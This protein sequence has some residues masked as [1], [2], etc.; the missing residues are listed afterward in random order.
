M[1][2]VWGEYAF[3]SSVTIRMAGG[4]VL[5]WL[6]A[7]DLMPA[8][9]IGLVAVAPLNAAPSAV[10]GLAS[11]TRNEL[12]HLSRSLDKLRLVAEGARVPLPTR[13]GSSGLIPQA[14]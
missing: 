2:Y 10:G 4:Q 12:K 1:E 7:P 11:T 13:T 5:P 9:I 3:D 8:W 6:V 14:L